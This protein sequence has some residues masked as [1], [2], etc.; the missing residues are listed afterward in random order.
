M[1][2][3]QL[4]TASL[5]ISMSI[6]LI[7][8]AL[9]ET[10]SIPTG[11]FILSVLTGSLIGGLCGSLI[12]TWVGSSD[13]ISPGIYALAGAA[14]LMAGFSRMTVWITIVMIE[15]SSQVTLTV[16]IVFSVMP[17]KYVANGI[18]PTALAE[19]VIAAKHVKFF[20]E[21]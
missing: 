3:D 1:L 17:A 10:L 8:F 2:D 20:T 11:T 21:H 13:N 6:V 14:G 7:F 16:P 12:S 9:T 4:T 19:R 18:Y 5:G 15:A